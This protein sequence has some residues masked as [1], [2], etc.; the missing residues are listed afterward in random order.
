MVA[1]KKNPGTSSGWVNVRRARCPPGAGGRSLVRP[2]AAQFSIPLT[3]TG[4]RRPRPCRRKGA[5]LRMTSSQAEQLKKRS[6]W[7]QL[8]PKHEAEF[9][10]VCHLPNKAAGTAYLQQT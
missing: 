4:S 6:V 2:G 8:L 7:W 10:G 3:P 5:R 9:M 1:D